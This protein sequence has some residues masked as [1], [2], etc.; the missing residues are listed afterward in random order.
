MLRLG[1][2]EESCSAWYSPVVLV[3]KPDG[4]FRFYNDFRRLNKISDFDAYPMGGRINRAARSGQVSHHAGPDQ[5][6]LAGAINPDGLGE[7]GGRDTGVCT[8]TPPLP[9]ASMEPLPPSRG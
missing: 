9:S 3:A 5:G 6:I 2:I 8:S 7:D 1:V 4:T